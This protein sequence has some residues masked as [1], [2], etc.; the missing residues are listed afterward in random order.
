[1]LNYYENG[2]SANDGIDLMISL[3]VRYPE[4]NTVKTD[5]K[6]GEIIFSFLLKK[7]LTQMEFAAWEQELAKNIDTFLFIQNKQALVMRFQLQV[8]DGYSFVEVV[9]DFQ[10]ISQREISLLI[11]LVHNHLGMY[12]LTETNDGSE[13][14]E[15]E[16]QEELID[17]LLD[18]LQFDATDQEDLIG[19]RD[20]GKVMVFQKNSLNN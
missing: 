5:P 1:M 17:D 14:E 2:Y 11:Q 13:V 6:V 3:L 10:T 4:I 8:Y 15:L 18:R 20:A 16:M 12:L 19:Y 7:E 9:R